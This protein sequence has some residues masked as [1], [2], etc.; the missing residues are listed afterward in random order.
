LLGCAQRPG[1]SFI[2]TDIDAKSLSY[3]RA[4]VASNNLE[5]RIRIV[6]RQASN[7]LIPL[8]D[9]D[10]GQVDFVMTNPPFYTS[11]S[12]LIDLAKL[13]VRPPNSACTGAPNELVCDGGEVGF[14]KRIFE[15]SR[16]VKERVQWYTT[17]LGKQSSLES[18]INVLKEHGI[19]NYAVTE[20][21]QGGKTRRWAVGWSFINRRPNVKVCRGFEPSAGKKLLPHLTEA[22]VASRLT[23]RGLIEQI[24]NLFWTQLEDVT[25]GLSLESW[26]MDEDRLRVVG[27]TDQNVWGRAYRRSKTNRSVTGLTATKSRTTKALS[28]CCFGFSITIVTEKLDQNDEQDAEHIVAVVV[29]WLQGNDYPLFESFSGMLRNALLRVL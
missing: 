23:R 22:T 16:E 17:M 4:N 29:R 7:R 5:S 1:W 2:A 18:V 19:D 21:V 13:K 27:F 25:D 8:D 12:E 14:F 3:A 28:Q 9:L 6:E 10:I 20:F 26:S 24:Q 11:K 15:E